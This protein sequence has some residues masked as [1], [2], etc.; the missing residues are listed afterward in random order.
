MY[1][2][3]QPIIVDIN[4]LGQ[5]LNF[6]LERA[7]GGQSFGNQGQS[8]F[9]PGSIGNVVNAG[10]PG[11]MS[12]NTLNDLFYQLLGRA[13]SAREVV[14]WGAY[15]QQGNSTNDLKVKLLSS[16]QFR[17]R[18]PN[19]AAYVQQL[20]SSLTNRVPD[21]QELAFWMGRMQSAMQTTGAPELVISEILAKNR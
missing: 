1:G 4:N 11:T 20:V 18:F 9:A 21:Q 6:V 17:D 10:Y 14:A 16:S 19:E 2:L 5:T 12:P 3:A 8:G 13:P 15:L 7:A